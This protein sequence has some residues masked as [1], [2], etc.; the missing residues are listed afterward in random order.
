MIRILLISILLGIGTS[1]A[2]LTPPGL[3]GAK[4]VGW[5]AL[6]VTQTLSAHWT[7]TI[8]AGT[9]TQSSLANYAFWQKPAISVLNQELAYQFAQHW[10]VVVGGSLRFQDLYEETPP[11]EPKQPAV[12]NEIRAYTRLFFRHTQRTKLSW[13]HSF[14]PEYRRFFTP[15]WQEWPNPFQIRLRLKSQLSYPLNATNTTQFIAANEILTTLDR[16]RS[17]ASQSLS[18]GPYKLSEDRLSMFIRRVLKKPAL[19]VDAGLMHQFWWD[20]TSQKI[21]YTT[22][23]SVDFLFRNPLKRKVN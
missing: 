20:A 8:Y 5:V 3:D 19:T 7:T 15:T 12:R 16:V 17:I 21:R 10:Q 9:S 13:A 23:L 22:Y 18:W 4:A 11:Y 1:K 2:Q 14:R 6:G